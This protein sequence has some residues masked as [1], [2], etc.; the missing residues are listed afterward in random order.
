[1]NSPLLLAA[2]ACF[3]TSGSFEKCALQPIECGQASGQIYRSSKWLSVNNADVSSECAEQEK[4]RKIQSLGRCD[5]AADRFICTSDKTACRFSAVFK[6]LTDDCNLVED[7]LSTNS[8]SNAHYGYCE[9]DRAQ[10]LRPNFCAWRFK[11]CGDPEL[12]EWN[13]AD[14]FFANDFPECHCD[15]VRTG[16]CVNPNTNDMYCAVVA[17]SC[18]GDDGYDYIPVLELQSDNMNIVCKLCDTLPPEL[19]KGRTDVNGKPADEVK[20]STNENTGINEA[21]EK[22]EGATD[23]SGKKAQDEGLGPGAII[24]IAVVAVVGI[25]V[26]LVGAVIIARRIKGPDVSDAETIGSIPSVQ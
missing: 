18:D 12:Y 4:I 20:G 23:S 15:D 5:G 10:E 16:A 17:A 13:I 9:G 25:G 22:T 8:F 11:E 26:I 14:P 24:G 21:P 2:G 7:F 6:P 1:M 19:I 3:T